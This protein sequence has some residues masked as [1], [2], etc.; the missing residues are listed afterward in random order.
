[1]KDNFSWISCISACLVCRGTN[2]AFIMLYIFKVICIANSCYSI[3]LWS[4]GKVCLM[5][6]IIKMPPFWT[7]AGQVWLLVNYKKLRFLKLRVPQM[8]CTT[9]AC[10]PST[11]IFLYYPCGNLEP[12]RIN[13][14]VKFRMYAVSW[15]L[16]FHQAIS[17]LLL[18]SMI[19]L[20]TN[21]LA[22]V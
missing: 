9:K 8:W 10:A 22:C 11:W 13:V 20:H 3:S 6:S 1:M 14:K 2:Y 16:F 17:S 15:V 4:R 21:F 5:S 18:V 12:K 7:M 19:L